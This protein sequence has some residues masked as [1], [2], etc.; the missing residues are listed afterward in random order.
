MEK[1]ATCCG[2]YREKEQSDLDH[3][4]S[5]E[6]L[7]KL[8]EDD[9]VWSSK[10]SKNS[11]LGKII[12]LRAAS[13]GVNPRGFCSLSNDHSGNALIDRSAPCLTSSFTTF[14]CGNGLSLFPSLAARY[15]AVAPDRARALMKLGVGFVSM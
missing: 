1:R 12:R 8:E 2:L 4:S 13:R 15:N 14:R 11:T 9:K 3:Q 10:S 7:G 5:V 6:Y